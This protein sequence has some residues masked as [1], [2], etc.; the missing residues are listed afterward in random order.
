MN[1]IVLA[2]LALFAGLAALAV[3][4]QARMSGNSDSTEINAVEGA[5]GT[6]VRG[7]AKIG[8][9]SCRERVYVLV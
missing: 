3:P 7:A 6:A 4:A 8:R 2:L 5:R 9:A 1:R